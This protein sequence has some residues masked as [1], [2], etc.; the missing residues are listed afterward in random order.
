[1]LIKNRHSKKE[2]LKR[3]DSLEKENELLKNSDNKGI[4]FTTTLSNLTQYLVAEQVDLIIYNRIDNIFSKIHPSLQLN[5]IENIPDNFNALLNIIHVDDQ[6]SFRSLFQK[7][8][9]KAT[10]R[11]Q[12]RLIHQKTDS[13]DVKPVEFIF[14]NKNSDNVLIVIKDVSEQSK[15][16]RELLK[17]KEKIEESDKLKATLLS[18]I[19]HQI[20]TP[21]NSITGF[22]ELLVSID[23]DQKKRKDYI[24]IIKR[25]SKRILNLI[26]DISEI[27]K[28]DAGTINIS[29]NP[30]NLKL[31]LNELM[32]GLNQQRTEKRKELVEL[33][34]KLPETDSFEI[35]TDSGRLHQILLNIINFSLRHTPQGK[36]QIGYR[37]DHSINK[38][39]FFIH[40]TSDGL[41]KDEQKVVF[42][43]F[44]VIDN[45]ENMKLEDP[46]LGLTIA[47]EIIKA[48]GGKIWVESEKGKGTSFYFNIPYEQ[49]TENEHVVEIHETISSKKN[50]LQNKVILIVDDEDVN[51]MFL[52]AVFQG[53]GVQLLFAK[54]GL[55]ALE[56]VK[57]I[58]KID[59]ILM[60]LKMP[61]M[62]GI[63]AT[64]EIRK[65]NTTI[66]IIA[67]TALVS[68]EDRI[69]TLSAGCNDTITKPIEVEEILELVNS[70]LAD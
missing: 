50:N 23:T 40:D 14:I 33:E 60:D 69:N 11:C 55:Q 15:Q 24:D 10:V 18:N 6:E 25:Q 7:L 59:L 30:C 21:L 64:Q 45:S 47:Y 62:N 66:P 67:Q 51:A 3:I 4:D 16:R 22:S 27:S 37:I 5:I 38:I 31:L 54:N 56:L 9:S 36:I 46:G 26:D 28:L 32:I 29:K 34:L 1:M 48:I 19:S 49:V 44:M 63:K 20:R 2:L 42:N 41:T 65:H 52:D 39:E 58:N 35:L 53:T 12:S 13:K 8:S 70:Y 43:R 61:V 17:A 57:N 68:E